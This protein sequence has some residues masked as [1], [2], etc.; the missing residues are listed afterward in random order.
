M[1]VSFDKDPKLYAF[2]DHLTDTSDTILLG[3]KMTEGFVQYW[4]RVAV[5]KDDPE[6]EFAQKMVNMPKVMFSK[7]V[8]QV[9][10]RTSAWRAGTWP[11]P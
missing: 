9:E 10:G 3:R 5:Q 7:T 8:R 6:F 1:T 11:P 2:I 4:E